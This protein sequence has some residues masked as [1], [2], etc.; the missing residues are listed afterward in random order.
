M[1]AS[2][3]VLEQ[4]PPKGGRFGGDSGQSWFVN[5][6]DRTVKYLRTGLVEGGISES[7]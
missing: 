2:S 1:T 4:T 3:P 6:A 7:S 5:Q